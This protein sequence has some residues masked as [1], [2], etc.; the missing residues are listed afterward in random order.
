MT[1]KKSIF[2]CS[3]YKGLEKIVLKIRADCR[4]Q[5]L[6][7]CFTAYEVKAGSVIIHEEK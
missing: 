7:T 5:A 6:K 1:D 4:S 2:I 3:F